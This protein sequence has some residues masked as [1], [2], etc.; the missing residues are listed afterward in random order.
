MLIYYIKQV[1]IHSI[2]YIMF[3][4]GFPSLDPPQ[5]WYPPEAANILT[6]TAVEFVVF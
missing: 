1:F 4:F 3:F 5:W 6:S 2:K